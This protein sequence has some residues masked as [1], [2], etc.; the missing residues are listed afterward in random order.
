MI[1]ESWLITETESRV[2]MNGLLESLMI[3]GIIWVMTHDS[4]FMVHHSW[5][6]THDWLFLTHESWLMIHDSWLMIHYSWFLTHD[7]WFMTHYS[8]LFWKRPTGPHTHID[9]VLNFGEKKMKLSAPIPASLKRQVKMLSYNK[10]AF[11][12]P[13][14]QQRTTT[15]HESVTLLM[16]ALAR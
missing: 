15:W 8:D 12:W 4:W 3:L 10:N 16:L 9:W 11:R 14:W 2:S 6:L 5:F 13:A 1:H 7:S